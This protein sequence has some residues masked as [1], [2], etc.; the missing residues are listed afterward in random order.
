[1][2]KKLQ[3]I[4]TNKSGVIPATILVLISINFSGCS[5]SSEPE[6]AKTVNQNQTA[7][8]SDNN[9][10]AN[11][12]VLA[13]NSVASNAPNVSAPVQ[14]NVSAPNASNTAAPNANKKFVPPANIPKPQIGSGGGDFFLLTQ[15]RAALSADQ[16]LINAVVVD[17]KEGNAVLT[18]KVSS[19]AQKTKAAQLIQSVKGVKSVKNNLRVSS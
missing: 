1:M 2:C 17:L 4:I 3:M 19:E 15:V 13:N 5:R 18:G 6:V 12:T 7:I 11:N 14:S 8:T 16:E 10:A 9:G